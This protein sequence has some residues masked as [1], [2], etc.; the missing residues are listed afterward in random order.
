MGLPAV[1]P[2]VLPTGYKLGDGYRTTFA[3]SSNPAVQVWEK[4]PK[5]PGAD[6]KEAIDTTTML[7]NRYRTMQPRQLITL[8]ESNLKA[9]YDP[10]CIVYFYAEIGFPQSATVHMPTNDQLSFFGFIQSFEPEPF[11]EGEMPMAEI[12]VT[13]TNW[14][15]VNFVEAGP[16]YT[17]ASGT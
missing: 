11:K 1:T 2:R 8:T 17:P 3:F 12:K 4:E 10:D 14:D 5:M 15:F 13:P 9:A 16:L 6:A 7:N